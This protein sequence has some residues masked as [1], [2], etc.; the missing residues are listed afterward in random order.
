MTS[1]HSVPNTSTTVV[2]ASDTSAPKRALTMA[3]KLTDTPTPTQAPTVTPKPTLTPQEIIT[4][5]EQDAQAVTVAQ[6][7]KT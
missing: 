1:D 7:Y 6:I 4:G 3:P 5:F 2:K